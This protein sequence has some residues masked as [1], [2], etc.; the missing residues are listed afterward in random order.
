MTLNGVCVCGGGGGL[1]LSRLFV[2]A[3]AKGPLA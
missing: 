3:F 1:S 2:G